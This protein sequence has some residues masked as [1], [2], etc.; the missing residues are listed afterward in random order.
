M[1]KKFENYKSVAEHG[2]SI[3]DNYISSL[4]IPWGSS[5][6]ISPLDIKSVKKKMFHV[7]L[8]TQLQISKYKN[9]IQTAIISTRAMIISLV[10]RKES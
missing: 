7:G 8:Q 2:E 9:K 4:L 6:K 10:P 5:D 3:A 1:D